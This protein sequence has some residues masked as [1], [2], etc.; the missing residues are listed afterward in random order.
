[1]KPLLIGLAGGTCAGKTTLAGRLRGA[2]PGVGI[3][4]IQFDSYYRPLNHLSLP[5]RAAVN[6][7]C[8]EALDR[9][10]FAAHLELLR[11]GL[12]APVPVYD[13]AAHARTPE[14]APVLPADVVVVEGIL[15]LADPALGGFL[16]LKVYLDVPADVRLARRI[17]R[18]MAERG[19]TAE[20]V[21]GQYFKSV[22]PMHEILVAPS[23]AEADLVVFRGGRDPDA[24]SAVAARVRELLP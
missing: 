3:S 14:T 18:D 22:R 21:I 8:L 5:E 6:F 12:P 11:G 1:M 10:L 2:L 17:R 15:L 16:D 24:L 19:R 13:F 20:S 7:D 4:C 23:R 9:E